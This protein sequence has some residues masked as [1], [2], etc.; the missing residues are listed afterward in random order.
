MK[1]VFGLIGLLVLLVSCKQVVA[2]DLQKFY[3]YN[4]A[5]DLVEVR[6]ESRAV[7]PVS[8]AD[9]VEEY[10]S[11]NDADQLFVF[12]KEVSILEAPDATAYIVNSETYEPIYIYTDIP[13]AGFGELRHALEVDTYACAGK[14]FIDKIP[15]VPE[16][17]VPLPDYERYA[18][19]LIRPDG[20]IDF[21]TH[22]VEWESEGYESM[23]HMF[24]VMQNAVKVQAYANGAGWTYRAGS[25]YPDPVP[26]PVV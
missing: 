22:C 8:L 11:E 23:A 21:E 7:V 16:P 20:S 9:Y 10:N 19:Y 4:S 17:V 6:T 3:V 24:L 18:A 5:W 15:P 1:R 13:R 25:L 12:D 14:L 2:P 26:E